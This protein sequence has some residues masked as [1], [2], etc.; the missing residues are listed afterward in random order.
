MTL[1]EDASLP[2][3]PSGTGKGLAHHSGHRTGHA[4]SGGPRSGLCVAGP[5]PTLVK[6]GSQDKAA[7]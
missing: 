2:R 7:L 5:L 3:A 4:A 1:S 6:L